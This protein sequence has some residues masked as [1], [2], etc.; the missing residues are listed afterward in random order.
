MDAMG[1]DYAPVEIVNGALR[2][3]EELGLEIILVGKG[4]EIL[5]VLEKQGIGELPKG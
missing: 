1:G 4:E 3:I 2:G 5:K